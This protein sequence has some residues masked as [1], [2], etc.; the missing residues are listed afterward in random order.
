M[1][2]EFSN[3]CQHLAKVPI[4]FELLILSY[5]RGTMHFT[6]ITVKCSNK[7][8]ISRCLNSVGG[9]FLLRVDRRVST[10]NEMKYFIFQWCPCLYSMHNKNIRTQKVKYLN[11]VKY[12][13]AL[14]L[15]QTHINNG[16]SASYK[17]H[18]M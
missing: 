11:V 13:N 7:V 1:E 2:E 6:L 17:Y 15:Q 16:E 5:T 12:L 18:S 10:S 8:N 9:C 4:S 14:H 3:I